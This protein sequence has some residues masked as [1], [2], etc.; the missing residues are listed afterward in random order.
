MEDDGV[1]L[2]DG[3]QVVPVRGEKAP[4]LRTPR[5]SEKI[6]RKK[7]DISWPDLPEFVFAKL[8]AVL[9]RPVGLA[10]GEDVLGLGVVHIVTAGSQ[11]GQGSQL[12]LTGQPNIYIIEQVQN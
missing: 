5:C 10:P 1:K 7:L 9:E 4:G 8:P 11:V 2:R 6:V 3:A 12:S